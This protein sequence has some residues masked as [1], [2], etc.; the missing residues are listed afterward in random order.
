M[1]EGNPF[2]AGQE[3]A[4]GALVAST[5]AAIAFPAA[6]PLTQEIFMLQCDPGAIFDAGQAWMATA[7]ALEQAIQQATSISDAVTA[8]GWTGTDHDAHNDKVNDFVTQLRLDQLLAIT[9]GIAMIATAVTMFCLILFA[10]VISGVLAVCAGIYWAMLAG[11]VTAPAAAAFFAEMQLMA[12]SMTAL[13][14]TASM[15]VEAATMGFA[16]AISALLAVDVAGQLFTGNPEVVSDLGEATVDSI[17]TVTAG[18]MSYFLN[19][20]IGEG[21]G[22]RMGPAIGIGVGGTTLG[23]IGDGDDPYAPGLNPVTW[24]EYFTLPENRDGLP[25]PR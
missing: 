12:G 15:G 5:T 18:L 14:K 7:E 17:G 1:S 25:D 2:T 13:F 23:G 6:W 8:T 11:I 22:G 24:P 3:M 4:L 9:I 16:A 10:V 19:K 21:I 20:G